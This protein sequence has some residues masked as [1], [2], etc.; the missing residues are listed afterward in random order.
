MIYLDNAATTK[1][2]ENAFKKAAIYATEKY[3]N[4]SAMYEEG[5]AI[6]SELKQARSVL[7]SGIADE[8]VFEW[9][10]T[11][12]GTEADNQAVFSFAKRGNAVTTIGEHSAIAAPF[13]ELK[14]RGIAE[15]RYAPWHSDGRVDV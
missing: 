6:Q 7:L 10:F 8:T 14:N 4:P 3:F 13:A 9:I 2:N 1:V 5:F 15:P 12:C 11:S